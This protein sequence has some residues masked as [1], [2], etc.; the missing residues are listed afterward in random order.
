MKRYPIPDNVRRQAHIG[1]NMQA[2]HHRATADRR[3]VGIR[4]A[5]QLAYGKTVTA[6]DL[7]DIYNWHRRH[8]SDKAGKHF[9]N[10]KKPSR[11]RTAWQL[12][13]SGPHTDDALRWA[14]KEL[15]L[16]YR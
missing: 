5:E 3:A 1:L 4:R 7:R 10:D 8:A 9:Y 12:W 2:E 13:G 15:G 16:P 14:A 6:D 11:G